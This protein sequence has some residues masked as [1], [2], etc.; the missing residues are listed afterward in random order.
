MIEMTSWQSLIPGCFA[1]ECAPFGQ[2]DSDEECAIRMF[3]LALNQKA[4]MRQVIEEAIKYLESRKTTDE[5][6]EEQLKLIKAFKYIPFANNLIMPKAWVVTWEDPE[7]KTTRLSSDIIAVFR[8]TTAADK[9]EDFVEHYYN[10][11]NYSLLEKV[12]Y[13]KN[14]DLNPYRVKRLQE[15][16]GKLSGKMTCGN[17]PY[18][19]ARIVHDLAVKVE[20]AGNESITWEE[21]P[22]IDNK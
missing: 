15:Q 21:V 22:E 18:I 9:I 16:G 4:N 11:S 7:N 1:F 14:K 5:M 20:D 13:A 3:H 12:I 8:S 10:S 2:H 19:L 17:N 6:I